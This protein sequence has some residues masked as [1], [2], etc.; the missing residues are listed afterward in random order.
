MNSVSDAVWYNNIP[1]VVLDLANPTW[2]SGNGSSA[3]SGNDVA[4]VSTPKIEG[5]G[6]A[7][8]VWAQW[9]Q[10]NQWYQGWAW[11]QWNQWVQWAQGNQWNQGN[12][13]T[14]WIPQYS[15]V[16]NQ[17][18]TSYT[19]VLADAWKLITLSNAADI[20]LYVLF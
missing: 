16:N 1:E 4:W 18:W 11:A 10:G 20:A 6:I 15:W 7:W 19:L 12:Q 9:P 8:W 2:V 13:W 17:T 3:G 5:T 14:Q